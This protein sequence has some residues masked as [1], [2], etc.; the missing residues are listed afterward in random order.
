MLK[1]GLKICFPILSTG[2]FINTFSQFVQ[3][4]RKK[5]LLCLNLFSSVYMSNL[6]S[7][8][9]NLH[10]LF[11]LLKRVIFEKLAGRGR[12]KEVILLVMV[13]LF[14]VGLQYRGADGRP[15]FKIIPV[16]FPPE[17]WTHLTTQVYK[18]DISVFINGLE[19]DG[20]PYA[21]EKLTVSPADLTDGFLVRVGQ[22]VSGKCEEKLKMISP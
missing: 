22:R 2:H 10:L 4:L 18:R 9:L 14:S 15:K 11:S 7:A 19:A 1:E 16:Q 13:N 20:T 17:E 8:F 3:H 12:R 21:A 6:H 5:D